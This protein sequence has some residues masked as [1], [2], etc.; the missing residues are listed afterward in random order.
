M[1]IRFYDEALVDKIQKWV[2]DPKIQILKPD[3]FSRLIQIK[4]DQNKDK[5]LTLPLIALSR[6]SQLEIKN[7]SKKALTF[8]G[9]MFEA[10]VEKTM[11][12]NAIPILINYQLDIYTRYFEE[13]DEYLR[14]FLFNLINHPKLT[15]KIP[16]NGVNLEHNA[17]VNI[18]STVEDNSDIPQRLFSDQF[19]R[20]TI[21]LVID[22][23]Y[24]FSVPVVKNIK[25]SDTIDVIV[26]E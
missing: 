4:A 12:L 21:K 3:E 19:T 22:E 23:A 5:P 17:Y 13:A 14:E 15:I 16:Y 7:V 26:K 10:N 24:L 8:D 2:K 20:F 6:E 25:M 9:M 11:Q 18:L 1:A